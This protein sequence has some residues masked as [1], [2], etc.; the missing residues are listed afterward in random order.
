MTITELLVACAVLVILMA[1][2]TDIIVSGSRASENTTAQ[3]NAQ[4][5]L[6]VGFDRLEF[7]GRCASSATLVS[8]G[9]GVTFVLP[10]QCAHA[11]GTYTWCVS[12]GTLGRYAGSACSG[13]AQVFASGLT[14]TT[15]FSL[16]TSTGTLPR[17]QVSMAIGNVS[18]SDTITLR[19]ASPS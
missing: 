11:A 10:S 15:P 5:N 3:I 4:Q 17:L 14:S 2:V 18:E 13:T 16:L 12:S 8:G 9:A 7:E 1:G 6:R 19:N